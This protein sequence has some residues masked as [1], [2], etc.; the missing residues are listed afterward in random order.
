MVA[1][2]QEITRMTE[3]CD[4]QKDESAHGAQLHEGALTLGT[5]C[6][7]G[8]KIPALKHARSPALDWIVLTLLNPDGHKQS[9]HAFEAS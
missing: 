3:Q 6:G 7:S 8:V 4:V 1:Q 9:Q 5:C 2:D